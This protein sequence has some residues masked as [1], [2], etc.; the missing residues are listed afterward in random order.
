MKIGNDLVEVKRF[1]ELVSN[2]R[3]LDRVFS[4]EEQEHIFVQKDK[5]KIAERIA[6]KYA[7]KEA[8]AKALGFGISG[9]VNFLNITVL[10]DEFGAPTVKLLDEAL[11]IFKKNGFHEIDVSISNTSEYAES[12]CLLAWIICL[13][14][15]KLKRK[16]K[17]F[18]LFLFFGFN[19]WFGGINY[20]VWF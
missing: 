8:V 9:G 10:P 19:F 15:Q 2:K 14:L 18:L 3:F 1:L 7:T 6:G 4:P 5:Q 17:N 13:V 20:Y 11:A 16:S 12:V